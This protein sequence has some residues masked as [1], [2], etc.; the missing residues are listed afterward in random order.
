[1]ISRTAE[2]ALRAVLL[3]SRHEGEEL[4]NADELADTL[5]A[6]R[7]YLSKTLNALVRHGVLTST[8]GP[9][10]GFALAVSPAELPIATVIEIFAEPRAEFKV[11][12]LGNQLCNPASPCA[13]H[14][15]WTNITVRA[16]EPLMRTTIAEL[17]G[18]AV[19]P[20]QT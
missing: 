6:P 15:C 5:G 11:C 13:A 9:R 3:L 12:M 8:R 19:M 20:Q 16:R 18:L 7:N 17:A 10:G 14:E 4:L 1:M 2:Y